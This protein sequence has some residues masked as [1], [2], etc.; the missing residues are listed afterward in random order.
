MKRMIQTISIFIVSWLLL[1]CKISD[2]NNPKDPKSAAFLQQSFLQ[3]YVQGLKETF[4]PHSVAILRS[5]TSLN[6]GL[7]IYPVDSEI[8][9]DPNTYI[10]LMAPSSNSGFPGNSPQKIMVPEKTRK[11]LYSTGS[12]SR[13]IVSLN[14]EDKVK[15]EIK[16][17]Q[18]STVPIDTSLRRIEKSSDATVFYTMGS[19]ASGDLIQ[20]WGFDPNSGTITSRNSGSY[21][22]GLACAPLS[23]RY[24][25]KNDIIGVLTS[26]TG[27]RGMYFYKP[28][29]PDSLTKINSSTIDFGVLTTA[30]DNLS[31][32]PEKNYFYATISSFPAT[33]KAFLYSDSGVITEISGSPFSPDPNISAIPPGVNAGTNMLIDPNGKY[34]AIVYTAGVNRYLNLLSIDKETGAL[35]Q[36]GTKLSVGNAPSNLHWDKSGQFIYL[37]S[38]TGGSTNNV[39]LEYFK[40]SSDGIVVRGV[41]SP[42]VVNALG[43]N[44]ISDIKSIN[45]NYYLRYDP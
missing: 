22:F 24:D 11:I 6:N 32:H 26:Q 39:Q 23:I 2:L 30:N 44:N 17:T 35:S 45:P 10:E 40:V 41:N 27:S 14:Y 3:L 20:R 21:P 1:Q 9:I 38:D 15:I 28:T 43:S 8:G 16:D 18:T 25:S 5:S 13:K 12:Y 4:L 33:I 29:D 36:S 34:L 31:I 42:I 7:R 37:S 19:G